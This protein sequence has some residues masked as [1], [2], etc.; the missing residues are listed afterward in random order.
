M[1]GGGGGGGDWK[2]VVQKL[3]GSMY[4]I[5]SGCVWKVHDYKEKSVMCGE[6]HLVCK[7]RFLMCKGRVL[8]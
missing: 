7:Q 2:W 5:C 1:G 6:K 8:G 4:G 3:K